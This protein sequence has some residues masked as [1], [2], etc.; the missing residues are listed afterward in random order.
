MKKRLHDKKAGIAI[1]AVLIL[2]SLAEVIFRAT[3]IGKAVLTT[4]NL[5]EQLAVIAL[6]AFIRAV[7]W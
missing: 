2:I 5:G 4:S 7:K 1:L 6:A 3:V